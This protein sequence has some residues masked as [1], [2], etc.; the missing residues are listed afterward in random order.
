M[1]E[2]WSRT[3]LQKDMASENINTKAEKSGNGKE[4][5][6][7]INSIDEENNDKDANDNDTNENDDENISTN[8][9][10]PNSTSSSPDKEKRKRINCVPI[11]RISM[12]VQYIIIQQAFRLNLW[13]I[14]SLFSR[15]YHSIV[16]L[17]YFLRSCSTQSKTN[18]F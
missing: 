10:T 5:D 14:T 8:E 2:V 17:V 3:L 1:K 11:P 7:A 9:T 16:H 4:I 15:S 18:F 6:D 13:P 12:M